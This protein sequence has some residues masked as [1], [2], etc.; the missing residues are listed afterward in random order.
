[1]PCSSPRTVV[2]VSFCGMLWISTVSLEGNVSFW[3]YL[4]SCWQKRQNSHRGIQSRY[5]HY[6]K[7][8]TPSTLPFRAFATLYILSKVRKYIRTFGT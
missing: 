1:M 7:S 2:H 5:T 4:R 6:I 3:E 8:Q